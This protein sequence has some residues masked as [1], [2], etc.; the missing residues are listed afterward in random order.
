MLS[1]VRHFTGHLTMILAQAFFVL[2]FF[3]L[4]IVDISVVDGQSMEPSLWDGDIYL[5]DRATLFARAPRRGEMVQLFDPEDPQKVL[6]KRVVGIPQD[7]LAFKRQAVFVRG[8]DGQEVEMEE[9]YLSPNEQ[10]I[11]PYGATTHYIIPNH[12]YFVLG[13]HRGY[14]HDSRQFGPVSRKDIIGL[15]RPLKR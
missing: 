7:D 3:K 9:P 6:V 4:F 2:L 13:D 5:V 8:K 1:R 11:L 12:H 15:V 14:S 10:T